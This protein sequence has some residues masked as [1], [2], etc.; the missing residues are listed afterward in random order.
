MVGDGAEGSNDPNN[1][2]TCEYMNNKNLKKKKYKKR[3]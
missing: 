1:I 3:R 2:C